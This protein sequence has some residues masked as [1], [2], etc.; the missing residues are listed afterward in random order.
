MRFVGLA[1][2]CVLL[3]TAVPAAAQEGATTRVAVVNVGAVINGYTKSQVA[4]KELEAE[5]GLYRTQAEKLRAEMTRLQQ[6]VS[7]AKVSADEK[8]AATSK[9][10]EHRRKLED[11][12]GEV[13]QVAGKKQEKFIIDV[14]SDMQAAI[15][16]HAEANNIDLV[17]MYNE[18]ERDLLGFPNISRKIAASDQGG[19]VP[20]F[21]RPRSEITQA[22]L[23]SLNDSYSAR[24]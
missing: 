3:L 8:T 20:I 18:P 2:L 22:V 19:L 6:V 23:Q 4:K 7:D 1:G 9:L 5:F 14:Y 16:R 11:L 12:E 17:L 21:I 24:K 10:V 13:R 15:Q